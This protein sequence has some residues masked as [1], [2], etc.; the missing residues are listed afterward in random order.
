MRDNNGPLAGARAVGALIL[1]VVLVSCAHA[2]YEAVP[3]EEV[4]VQP[5]VVSCKGEI[6]TPGGPGTRWAHAIFTVTETGEVVDAQ[7]WTNPQNRRPVPRTPEGW[8]Q[9]RL[10][11]NWVVTT[12]STCIFEPARRDNMPVAVS[13]VIRGFQVPG[14]G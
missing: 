1:P 8:E 2:A 3:L 9:K 10:Q 12:A 11:D 7:P 4:D 13:G 14:G 5:V 6:Q